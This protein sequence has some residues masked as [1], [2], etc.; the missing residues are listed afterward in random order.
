MDR[1]GH[2][3]SLSLTLAERGQ[4]LG[5]CELEPRKE[6]WHPRCHLPCAQARAG[7]G[8]LEPLTCSMALDK[9]PSHLG[10]ASQ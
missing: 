4:P 5:T 6:C 1:G 10:I 3:F 2:V 8:A 9:S 7:V